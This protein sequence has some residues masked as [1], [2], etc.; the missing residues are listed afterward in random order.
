MKLYIYPMRQDAYDRY[1]TGGTPAPH[2]AADPTALLGSNVLITAKNLTVT[3]HLRNLYDHLLENH[4]L[5][6]ITGFNPDILDIFSREV[7]AR[8]KARD[9]S[10]ETMVPAR[11]AA[12]I[13][14]RQLFGYTE[15]PAA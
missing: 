13:K 1:L 10:W 4:Y 2:K 5:E 14:K 7:L 12:A 15:A 6:C 11:V 8:I 9:A 3:P